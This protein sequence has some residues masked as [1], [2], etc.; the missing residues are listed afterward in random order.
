MHKS[1]RAVCA[2]EQQHCV[3]VCVR[4]QGVAELLLLHGNRLAL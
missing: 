4:E 3:F 1:S 2:Q